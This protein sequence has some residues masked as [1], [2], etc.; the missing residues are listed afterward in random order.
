MFG[1]C[2]LLGDNA[3][4]IGFVNEFGGKIGSTC[5]RT[6]E[7]LPMITDGDD[8]P[9]ALLVVVV[10]VEMKDLWAFG[11]WIGSLFTE[12][13]IRVERPLR[14]VL[15]ALKMA[16]VDLYDWDSS[17]SGSSSSSSAS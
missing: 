10:V 8:A 1:E 14:F 5:D 9:T 11:W 16:L 7:L 12:E 4:F 17:L 6:D 15:L 2:D 3:L 13:D